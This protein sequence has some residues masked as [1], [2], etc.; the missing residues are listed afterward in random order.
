LSHIHSLA[1]E[2]LGKELY[3]TRLLHAGIVTIFRA[4]KQAI[5]CDIMEP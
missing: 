1:F 2:V 4:L 3:G 5:G